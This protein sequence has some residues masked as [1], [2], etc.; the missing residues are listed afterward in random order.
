MDTQ[1]LLLTFAVIISLGTATYVFQRNSDHSDCKDG[2]C[3]TKPEPQQ[4]Q[5][6]PEPQPQPE[7][8]TNIN[9]NVD[10]TSPEVIA[11]GTPGDYENVDAGLYFFV[12]GMYYHK[13]YFEC[14]EGRPYRCRPAHPP[15]KPPRYRPHGHHH[16]PDMKRPDHGHKPDHKPDRK[17]D[18]KRPENKRPDRK[19]DHAKRPDRKPDV[20]RPENKRPDR[21]PDVKRPDRDGKG[22]GRDRRI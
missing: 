21:K 19:P 2:A 16:K 3:P 22:K 5:P 17:P 10:V 11:Y 14:R 13:H 7:T 6:Q 9:V 15:C 18:V 20:K 12:G 1:R 4:A 8:N